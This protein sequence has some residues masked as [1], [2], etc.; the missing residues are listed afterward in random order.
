[1]NDESKTPSAANAADALDGEAGD[2]GLVSIGEI[3]KYHGITTRTIRFYEAK[4][5][6]TPRRIG[7]ARAYDRR[8]RARLSVILLGKRL[9]FSLEE[10]SE[11]LDLYDADPTQE[12][13]WQHLLDKVEMAAKDLRQKQADITQ[14]LNELKDMSEICMTELAKLRGG[15]NR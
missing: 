15:I 4:N 9:G 14:T 2:A 7:N 12:T 1:M 5:L 3:A 13:Q 10:I 11:Y 8:D 6:I